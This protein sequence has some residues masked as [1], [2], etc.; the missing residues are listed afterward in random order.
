MVE[1]D[2]HRSWEEGFRDEMRIWSREAGLALLWTQRYKKVQ[3][4]IIDAE[5][6]FRCGQMQKCRYYSPVAN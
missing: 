4:D 1:K 3:I 5:M 2:E 6:T